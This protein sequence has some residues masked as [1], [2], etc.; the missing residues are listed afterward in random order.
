[1]SDASGKRLQM[2]FSGPRASSY[3]SGY[4]VSGHGAEYSASFGGHGLSV[5]KA[6]FDFG[7][8]G[9]Q[10][11]FKA[12][13]SFD[14]LSASYSNP[15]GSFKP[16]LSLGLGGSFGMQDDPQKKRTTFSFF[17]MRGKSGVEFSVKH[18]TLESFGKHMGEFQDF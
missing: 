3:A 10:H 18:S 2:G 16:G 11:G 14:L 4:G 13:A 5:K 12:S 6:A 9:N 7:V 15:S 17:P 8:Q 1:M